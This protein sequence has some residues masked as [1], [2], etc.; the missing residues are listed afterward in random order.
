MNRSICEDKRRNQ[1]RRGEKKITL[2]RDRGEAN[3]ERQAKGGIREREREG[4]G[5]KGKGREGKGNKKEHTR[6]RESQGM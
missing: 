5:R 3:T 2:R 4:K 1:K 6:G